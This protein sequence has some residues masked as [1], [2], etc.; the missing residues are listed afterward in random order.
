MKKKAK[1]RTVGRKSALKLGD[2]LNR[3]QIAK[4]SG[5]DRATVTKYLAAEGA[6][7]PDERMCWSFKAAMEWFA[8]VAPI[9]GGGSEMKKLREAKLRVEAEE[10]AFDFGIKRGRYIEREEIG[11]AIAAFNAQL[12]ADLRAKFEFELPA[13]YDG[14]KTVERQALNAAAID[15][16]L[17]RLKHGQEAIA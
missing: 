14:K 1:V 11:P 9:A 2:R 17:K 5:L 6:P 10:A 12:T 16:I 8:Q 3:L 13:K 7:P 4:R 15:W